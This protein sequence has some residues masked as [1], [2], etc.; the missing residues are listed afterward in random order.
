[1]PISTSLLAALTSSAAAAVLALPAPAPP[2]QATTSSAPAPAAHRAALP[3]GHPITELVGQFPLPKLAETEAHLSLSPWGYRF[4][5]GMAN[6]HLTVTQVGNRLRFVDTAARS[7]ASTPRTCKRQRVRG[8]AA[9][10]CRI[11]SRFRDRMFVEIWPRLGH[12]YVDG[13]TLSRRFRMWVLTDAGNDTIHLGAGADFGNGAFDHDTVTGGRGADW[14]R[15]GT[16]SNR[17]DGGSGGDRLMG[18]DNQDR[19]HGG[20]GADRLGGLRGNDYLWGDG[21]ADI[22][23]GGP[24]H[25][26][27]YAEGSD[28]IK[29]IEVQH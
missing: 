14:I 25:D 18:G 7:W 12:D 1:M 17:I 27:A 3:S 5:A 16:G 23:V 20:P 24:G 6:N 10:V 29:E 28:R 4:Q 19:I 15:V 2:S 9:A 22:L 13:S 11:P 26:V 21:D 8:A